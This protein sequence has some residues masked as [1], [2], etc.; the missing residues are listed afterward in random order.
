MNKILPIILVV[1]LSGC[2]A[3]DKDSVVGVELLCKD[4]KREGHKLDKGILFAIDFISEE[5]FTVFGFRGY[6][7]RSM[8]KKLTSSYVK[9]AGRVRM[10]WE[11]LRVTLNRITLE[12]TTLN[13]IGPNYRYSCIVDEDAM[14]TM[15]HKIDML[16]REAE[17]RKKDY[18]KE[19]RRRDNETN[20]KIRKER[21][22]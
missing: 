20:E 11:G 9:N 19:K 10:D 16:I 22:I 4:T 13:Q 8:G 5:E 17:Q 15:E 1:V 21:Q 14:E 18:D 2:G 7:G 12:I 6:D 3:T